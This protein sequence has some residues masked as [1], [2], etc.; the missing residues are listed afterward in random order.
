MAL[1]SIAISGLCQVRIYPPPWLPRSIANHHRKGICCNLFPPSHRVTL[2]HPMKLCWVFDFSIA[3]GLF[4]GHTCA[5]VGLDAAKSFQLS[6]AS[7]CGSVY[8]KGFSLP[9]LAIQ[10]NSEVS[11][12]R[13]SRNFR[14]GFGPNVL[15]VRC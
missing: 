9:K 11:L 13:S 14:F 5:L 2:C 6:H 7:H 4:G 15:H 3:L 12:C 10:I 8:A 1:G